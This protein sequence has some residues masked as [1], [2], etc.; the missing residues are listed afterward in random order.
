MISN[1]KALCLSMCLATLSQASSVFAAVFTV[2]TT[3][4]GGCDV[5]LECSLIAAI[6]RANQTAEH[7]TITFN[8]PGPGVHRIWF[9]LPTITNPL[10]IDGTTQP[11]YNSADPFPT[12]M[13]SID[14]SRFNNNLGV[15]TIAANDCTIK[16]LHLYKGATGMWIEGR[17]NVGLS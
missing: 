15:V 8:I 14:G 4:S 6:S 11:G 9:I 1:R 16:G 5:G 7:D 3:A 12:P 10:T 2:T 17:R 13:I